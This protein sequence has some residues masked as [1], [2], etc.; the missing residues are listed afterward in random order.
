[1]TVSS[2]MK[3]Y[4]LT[5]EYDGSLFHGWQK[6]PDVRTVEGEIESAFSTLFQRDIDIIGQGRTDAG[7]H[8]QKQV[9]H[10]DLPSG[11]GIGKI[12]HAMRGLLPEDVSLF[13]I[14]EVHADFHARFDAV[15]RSYIYQI[16]VEPTPLY[17]HISWVQYGH[18]DVKVLDQCAEMICGHHDFIRFCIPS[19]DKYQTTECM[20]TESRWDH[21]RGFLVYRITGDR[22]LRQMVRRLVGT[23]V[24]VASEKG[25]VSEFKALL[26][27]AD[28]PKLKVFTAPAKGLVLEDVFYNY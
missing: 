25:E 26:D 10:A 16:A 15:S 18:P 27:N 24:L 5:F 19:G 17:R 23:M 7:V 22:F 14:E 20:I 11:I 9:A 12:D 1:M 4:K 8:A 2:F 13:S 21:E 28:E 6:Q 3:R